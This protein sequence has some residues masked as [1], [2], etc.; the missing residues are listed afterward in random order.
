MANPKQVEILKQG[1]GAWNQW[2]KKNPKIKPDLIGADLTQALLGGADLSEANLRM[3]NLAMANLSG[4]QLSWA[5][6]SW[7]NLFSTNFTSASI[8]GANFTDSLMRCTVFA[9]VDLSHAQGL[10]MVKHLGPSTIGLDTIERSRGKIPDV[11]LRGAGVSDDLIAFIRA[12]GGAIQF[13]SC[14]I[15]YSGKDQLFAER[16]YADLQARGVRCWFA[17]HDVQGGKKLHEQ[18]DDAIQVQE[19][20]LLILSPKSIH[21]EWVKTEIIKASKRERA[22][23]RRMLFPVRLKISYEELKKWKCFDGDTGKD[24][25]REIREYYI[26]DFSQWESP[27]KFKEEFE[28]LV[29]DLKKAEDVQK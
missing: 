11:F 1:V 7:A 19:R 27:E 9:D 17:P 16:L 22:E 8:E 26:P 20:V 18:I 15:S 12:M 5:I 24:L 6:L 3:A 4:A 21:S 23:K 29:H 13:Y 14:F 2:R 10:R 25:A 28:K